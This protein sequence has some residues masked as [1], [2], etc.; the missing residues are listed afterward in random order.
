MSDQTSACDDGG[1]GCLTPRRQNGKSAGTY[2]D[3]TPYR[4]AVNG[5]GLYHKRHDQE[6]GLIGENEEIVFFLVS[7]NNYDQ[8]YFNKT[9]FNPDTYTTPPVRAQCL[10]KK[11]FARTAEAQHACKIDS[12]VW[13]AECGALTR[14]S[15]EYGIAFS[16]TT[17]T[18]WSS[19]QS[20]ILPLI[21]GR[22][23]TIRPSGSWLGDLAGAAIPTQ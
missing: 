22:P 12:T 13:V 3:G 15:S 4:F 2:D 20:T 8:I 1:N 18:P 7:N 14:L 21:I 23:P 9:A 10:L 19:A 6:F 11:V 17:P 5:D 16:S